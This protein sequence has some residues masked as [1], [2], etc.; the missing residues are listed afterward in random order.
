MATVDRSRYRLPAALPIQRPGQA[1]L[2]SNRLFQRT[3]YGGR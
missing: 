3:T 1:A 2:P